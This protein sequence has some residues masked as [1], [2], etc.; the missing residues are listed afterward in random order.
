MEMERSTLP[1]NV[2]HWVQAVTSAISAGASHQLCL[3]IRACYCWD[4]VNKKSNRN[5]TWNMINISFW[6]ANP[7]V[8]HHCATTTTWQKQKKPTEDSRI[9]WLQTWPFLTWQPCADAMIF[10]GGNTLCR[11]QSVFPD[12]TAPWCM[13]EKN[14]FERK[15]WRW[16]NQGV[17]R[18]YEMIRTKKTIQQ[19]SEF[20]QDIFRGFL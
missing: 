2:N 12:R 4:V 14:S 7:L 19:F 20:E 15:T 18:Q 10:H 3:Q 5:K 16:E 13:C 17:S 6:A 8:V 1:S 11:Y 9:S